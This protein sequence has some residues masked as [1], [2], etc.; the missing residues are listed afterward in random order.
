MKSVSVNVSC[1]Q[2]HNIN[3]CDFMLCVVCG[4]S[5]SLKFNAI[6]TTVKFI[7][8]YKHKYE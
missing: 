2:Q 3:V 8:I 1:L 4:T 6:C 7:I 5:K